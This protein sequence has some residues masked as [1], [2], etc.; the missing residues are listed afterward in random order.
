MGNKLNLTGFSVSDA[1]VCTASGGFVGDV[2]GDITGDVTGSVTTAAGTITAGASGSAI[3]TT[4]SRTFLVVTS[5]NADHW[6][7]LPAP[8]IGLE[9]WLAVGANGC[10]L[11]TSDPTT[12]SINGGYGANAESA[13]ATSQ[14]VRCICTSATTWI[15]TNFDVDGTV[16]ALEAAA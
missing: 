8:S 11:R 4:G 16:T 5:A 9:I 7:T 6:V 12:I 1:N 2:T 15:A 10:E 14:L 3:S 13:I